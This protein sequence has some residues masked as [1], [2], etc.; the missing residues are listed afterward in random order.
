MGA[1]VDAA[2]KNKWRPLHAACD[3]GHFDC[4]RL[5]VNAGADVDAQAGPNGITPFHRA[6]AFN[7]VEIL[8]LLA[9]SGADISLGDVF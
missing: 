4:A 8:K 7:H 2:G 6:A 9:H 3:K 5:L 1:P